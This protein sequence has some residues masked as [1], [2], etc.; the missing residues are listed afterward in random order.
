MNESWV[1]VYPVPEVVKRLAGAVA[2][3]TKEEFDVLQ[4]L[5]EAKRTIQVEAIHQVAG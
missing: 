2:E 3:A 4:A 1:E 5:A